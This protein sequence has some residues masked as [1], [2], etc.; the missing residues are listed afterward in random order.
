MKRDYETIVFDSS[1]G[2]A[3]ITLN[4]PEVMNAINQQMVEELLAAFDQAEND[5]DVRVI[6]LTGSGTRAFCAGADVSGGSATFDYAKRPAAARP[7]LA[8]DGTYRDA[9]GRVALRIY[10]CLKPVIAAING[11]AAGAGATI[12]LPAD[13]RIASDTARFAYVFGRR[14]IV[15]E[16]ASSWFLPR[17]VGLQTALQWCLTGRIVPASEALARNLVWELCT[18]D[19]LLDRAKVLARE[20]ADNIAPVS[21]ALIRQMLWRLSAADHPMAAHKVD[22]RLIHEIGRGPDAQEGIAAFIEK[23][24]PHFPGRVPEDLPRAF[25]WWEDPSFS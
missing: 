25:P 8:A 12:I 14:G 4:R 9:G 1:D 2:I 20:I 7:T 3:V 24:P 5:P 23:R 18:P 22:S 17:I 6:I 21:A 16:S 15:P 13:I 19:T 10:N 11:A